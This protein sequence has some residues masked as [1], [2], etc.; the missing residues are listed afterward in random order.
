MERAELKKLHDAIIVEHKDCL[1]VA[2]R[3]IGF[4]LVADFIVILCYE[5]VNID[6]HV[7]E[8]DL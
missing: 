5:V 8:H 2:N 3:S 4:D 6:Y 7:S 1:R